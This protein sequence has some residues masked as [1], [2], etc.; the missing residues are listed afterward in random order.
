MSA[1]LD[2]SE[3]TQHSTPVTFGPDGP[4]VPAWCDGSRPALPSASESQRRVHG[5]AWKERSRLISALW[6]S[7]D[8]AMHRR[9]WRIN[10]CCCAPLFCSRSDGGVTM[11]P[12]LCRD[13][14]CPTCQRVRARQAQARLAEI[15]R[16]M[17]APRFLTLT[18][19][20]QDETLSAMIDRLYTAFREIRRRREWR[21]HV[22]GG[23]AVLEV[24]RNEA[25]GQWH[26]HLHVI[27]DGVFWLQSSIAKLW[28]SVTGDS[29]IVDIRPVHGQ[30]EAV[31]YLTAYLSK[32]GDAGTWDDATI[33][34]YASSMHRRRLI[35]TFGTAHAVRVPESD[36]GDSVQTV[37]PLVSAGKLIRALGAKCPYAARAVPLLARV[38]PMAARLVGLGGVYGQ[39]RA[40]PLEPGELSVL[41]V[42]L[43]RV[44]GDSL[45]WLPEIEPHR[46]FAGRSNAG[47]QPT[48][49][50][51]R[52]FDDAGNVPALI[53]QPKSRSPDNAP[54]ARREE[55]TDQSHRPH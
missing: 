34:E 6:E 50:Q 55:C 27:V 43:R 32:G 21:R 3:T 48:Y 46:R 51:L 7:D 18:L 8:E 52:C 47:G 1:S 19:R 37:A 5:H 41:T 2:H 54:Q 25:N 26:A 13:R 49:V 4:E 45:A 39:G 23:V 29:K 11:Q 20:S 30:R 28:L 53:R 14:L 24:T 44:G 10:A 17:N 22:H 38:S 31:R 40:T 9:A 36:H 42:A 33:V 16:A 15:V 35:Q 12:G